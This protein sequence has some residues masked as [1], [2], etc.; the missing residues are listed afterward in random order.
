M[1][2]FC[3][4]AAMIHSWNRMSATGIGTELHLRLPNT[5][6]HGTSTSNLLSVMDR[7]AGIANKYLFVETV[8]AASGLRRSELYNKYTSAIEIKISDVDP[9]HERRR[10]LDDILRNLRKTCQAIIVHSCSSREKLKKRVIVNADLCAT[11][12]FLASSCKI[13]NMTR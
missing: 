7:V 13:L 9:L 12:R 3:K 10:T 11:V 2:G 6:V 1:V 5:S 8:I 4:V